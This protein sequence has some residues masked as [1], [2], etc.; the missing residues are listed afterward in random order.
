LGLLL[1]L[2]LVD[3][4]SLHLVDRFVKGFGK[5]FLGAE[6]GRAEGICV[7]ITKKDVYFLCICDLQ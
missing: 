5:I 3:E 6:T 7:N 2:H 1:C 4:Y